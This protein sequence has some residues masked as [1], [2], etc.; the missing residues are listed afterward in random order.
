M[1]AGRLKRAAAPA[2]S[3]LPESW[4]L[5][6]TSDKLV[7]GA[8]EATEPAA[9]SLPPPPPQAV[10]KAIAALVANDRA[11]FPCMQSPNIVFSV[12]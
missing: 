3:R 10:T 8:D 9:E 12:S 1:P 2:P 4:A 7:T 11:I 6:A 5:P